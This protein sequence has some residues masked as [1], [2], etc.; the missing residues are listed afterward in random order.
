[1]EAKKLYVLDYHDLYL[2]VV[3]QINELESFD[4]QTYATRSIFFLNK[5]NVLKPCAIEL[6][7]EDPTGRGKRVFTP[8][9]N[10]QRDWMWDLAKAHVSTNDAG[11]HQLYSHWYVQLWPHFAAIFFFTKFKLI[12]NFTLDNLHSN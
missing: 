8:P 11:V 5:N 1:L 9:K 6:A 10:N 3:K 2:P 4:S 7:V 12:T